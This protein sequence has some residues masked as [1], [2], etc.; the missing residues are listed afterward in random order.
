MIVVSPST[1][2]LLPWSLVSPYGCTIIPYVHRL[3]GVKFTSAQTLLSQFGTVQTNTSLQGNLVNPHMR[4]MRAIGCRPAARD[5]W[6]LLSITGFE[7]RI[8]AL[9][10]EA[11][12]MTLTF[13]VSPALLSGD[14]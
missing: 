2:V 7:R 6:L 3:G 5:L 10:P 11:A 14:N 13:H 12:T 9:L 8:L 4:Q 1:M